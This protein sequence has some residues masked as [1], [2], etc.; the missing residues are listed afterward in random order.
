NFYTLRDLVEARG[1]DPSVLRMF[2]VST[3]YRKVL[4]F[5]FEAL[6]QAAAALK[7]LRDFVY[8][9]EHRSF[10]AVET[11]AAAP[12]L[13]EAAAKFREGLEDDLNVSVALTAL[14]DLIRKA[15]TLIQEEKIGASEAKDLL[16]FVYKADGVLAV[17]PE[18][19]EDGIS[20]A[21][22]A[23]IEERERARKARD[24]AA[25]DRIRKELLE[26]GIV[27]EDTKDGIRWKK[28]LKPG[29][30]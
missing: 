2:L 12:L 15:N 13:S 8:E 1:V 3:H 29:S 22:R 19:G 16:S 26:S 21:L 7:R 23:K 20:D 6:D 14:F 9:L 17:L 10:P 11:T 30:N 18:R 4:N 5:T 28:A 25:A 27:L 24:W